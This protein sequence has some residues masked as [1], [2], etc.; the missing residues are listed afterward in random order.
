MS[1]R[2]DRI[3]LID[4][5]LA[6]LRDAEGWLTTR[7]IIER[8]RATYKFEKKLHSCPDCSHVEVSTYR[9]PGDEMWGILNRLA[10]RNLVVKI[11]DPLSRAC[12]WTSP[13]EQ[14]GDANAF[15]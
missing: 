1:T 3:A 10:S 2:T 15:S 5:I 14:E 13:Q 6:V 9:M 4:Q 11:K 12:F 8:T 7:E